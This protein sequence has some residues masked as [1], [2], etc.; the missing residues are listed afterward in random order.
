MSKLALRRFFGIFCLWAVITWACGLT[1]PAAPTADL[2]AGGNPPSAGDSNTSAPA[3]SR[4]P[5]S[6]DL[7]TAS[8][9]L[10]PLEAYQ[11]TLRTSF[12]GTAS[13][14]PSSWSKTYT[15][16][17]S[18]ARQARLLN[19]AD[20]TA[21]PDESLNGWI[22]GQLD[23]LVYTR[24]GPM[25][26]CSAGFLSADNTPEVI[27]LAQ[28]LPPAAGA[29]VENTQ[30]TLAGI[31]VT[32]Y[33]FDERAVNLAGIGIAQGEIWVANEG[34]FVVKYSLQIQSDKGIF[35]ADQTGT[36]TWEYALNS[37]NQA[38]E[39]TLPQDC[40]AGMNAI[41]LPTGAGGVQLIP[42]YLTYLTDKSIR[43]VADFYQQNLTGIGFEEQGVSVVND[44]E[45]YLEYTNGSRSL[46]IQIRPG[47]Q[48]SVNLM[49]AFGSTPIVE[50]ALPTPDPAA[51]A[52]G[53]TSK[54][55]S[56]ALTLLLGSDNTPSVFPS[57]HLELSGLSP[58]LNGGSG[59]IVSSS[60][61]I[62]ADVQGT[63]VHLSQTSTPEGGSPAVTE[64]YLIGD[65]NYLASGGQI[66]EDIFGIQMIW[67]SWPLEV[68]M[69]LSAASLGSEAIGSEEVNGR[70][71][72]KYLIDTAKADLTSLEMLQ[73][74][75]PMNPLVSEAHGT[76]WV[77][78][79]TG[80]LLKLNLDYAGTFKD[81]SGNVVG[82]APGQIEIVVSQVGN[83]AVSLP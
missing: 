40:P 36:M 30:E 6:F 23:G 7:T 58:A 37:I 20:D 68:L 79:E 19:I 47:E 73:R 26:P 67:L 1:A 16:S 76:I 49:M 15:L 2:P 14:T 59:T 12:T 74:M 63:N 61:Q 46:T 55:V 48:T 4:G 50:V 60:T 62:S 10:E 21:N 8:T 32:R 65:M 71:A 3:A 22:T 44:S 11:A 41:P 39:I 45:A 31:G 34:G 69:P 80:G 83:V 51:V 53:D 42:G 66:Q 64:G 82:S 33:R 25:D 38:F 24:L 13:G 18:R 5:G 78:Q 54:R 57:Y 17:V 52:A 28:M 9:G 72:D 81:L 35:D 70:M 29:E 27:E 75:L 56:S 43:E 77:D